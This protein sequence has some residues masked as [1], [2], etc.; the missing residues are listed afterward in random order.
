MAAILKIYFSLLLVNRHHENGCPEL[1]GSV[2]EKCGMGDF[3]HPTNA[4]KNEA[5]CVNCHKNH[6]SK[7][8]RCEI[9]KKERNHE[10]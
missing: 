3:D 2:C 9:S 10:N 7:S 5:K 8:N 6:Q 4:C 1:P